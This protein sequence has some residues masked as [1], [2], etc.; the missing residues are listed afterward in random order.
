[1]LL[2]P[3]VHGYVTFARYF[4]QL[5]DT[6]V[7]RPPLCVPTPGSP[8]AS[9]GIYGKSGSKR[10][11]SYCNT[12]SSLSSE[13]GGGGGGRG[14]SRS[15]FDSSV[16]ES[17]GGSESSFRGKDSMQYSDDEDE[18]KEGYKVGGYHA[19]KVGKIAAGSLQACGY[20]GRCLHLYGRCLQHNNIRF[21]SP[22]F[23]SLIVLL[24]YLSIVCCLQLGDVFADRY[25]VVK[26]LGWGHFSTV[27]MA[28]DDRRAS[29][30]APKVSRHILLK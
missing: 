29:P 7:D 24:I 9:G 22:A 6:I 12:D 13:L 18:G 14:S 15:S 5:Q 16:T 26:K 25:I 10:E 1:M 30:S 21:T 2:L 4:L 19:V 11:P 20:F 3:Y 27:W 17:P 8:P 28:R 23:L